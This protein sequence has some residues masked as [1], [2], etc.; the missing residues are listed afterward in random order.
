MIPTS[1]RAAAALCA[2]LALASACTSPPSPAIVSSLPA[3][4][5]PPASAVALPSPSRPSPTASSPELPPSAPS[6]KPP[7][8][9]PSP[10]PSPRPLASPHGEFALRAGA[11]LRQVTLSN[12]VP[13]YIEADPSASSLTICLA[14]LPSPDAPAGMEAADYLVLAAMAL[15]VKEC[16]ARAEAWRDRA[17]LFARIAPGSEAR[18]FAELSGMLGRS[19]RTMPDFRTALAHAKVEASAREADSSANIL[20]RLD[21]ASLAGGPFSD[22]PRGRSSSL[23]S[24]SQSDLAGW[25]ASSMGSERLTISVSG[26]ADTQSLSTA[27]ESTFGVLPAIKQRRQSFP[28]TETISGIRFSVCAAAALPASPGAFGFVYAMPSPNDAAFPAALLAQRALRGLM[29]IGIAQRGWAGASADAGVREDGPA[30]GFAIIRGAPSP[31]DALD[32]ILE[33]AARLASGQAALSAV[34]SLM[35]ISEALPSLKADCIVERYAGS[36]SNAGM[37]GL[38]AHS[39]ALGLGPAWHL[40]IIEAIEGVQAEEVISAFSAVAARAGLIQTVP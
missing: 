30:R 25:A 31:Q 36:A 5:S 16:Q 8:P 40:A 7:R 9:S 26:H 14:F 4:A 22:D 35:G 1:L 19:G 37:A 23:A 39:A 18:A 33:A 3:G 12:G 24:L 6:A 10:S 20:S 32:C 34:S 28:D 21:E 11:L 38:L 29:V 15:S 13:V 2:C 27:M 17:C